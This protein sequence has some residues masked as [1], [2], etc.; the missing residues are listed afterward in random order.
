MVEAHLLQELDR[1]IKYPSTLTS[2]LALERVESRRLQVSLSRLRTSWLLLY[3]PSL[4]LSLSP[5][6]IPPFQPI[7]LS[8]AFGLL[9][10]PPLALVASQCVCARGVLACSSSSQSAARSRLCS[11]SLLASAAHAL[12]SGVA[13]TSPPPPRRCV[14]VGGGQCMQSLWVLQVCSHRSSVGSHEGAE[15]CDGSGRP[16]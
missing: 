6:L 10:S 13:L 4:S 11:S 1:S 14:E 8:S 3:P 12:S 7:P 2:N 15:S 16:H 9:P 5:S